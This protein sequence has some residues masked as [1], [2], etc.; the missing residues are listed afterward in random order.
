MQDVAPHVAFELSLRKTW[1]DPNSF[2]NLD[3]LAEAERLGEQTPP[4]GCYAQTRFKEATSRLDS[5]K[6][7]RLCLASRSCGITCAGDIIALNLKTLD[8]ST[9]TEF[10]VS[11]G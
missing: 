1:S 6:I 2:A 11:T 9:L 7:C 4:D 10:L 8:F 3:S 5:P